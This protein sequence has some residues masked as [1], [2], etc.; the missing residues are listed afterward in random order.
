MTKSAAAPAAGLT[1]E[2]HSW[3]WELLL[4]LLGAALQ[5]VATWALVRALTPDDAGIYF[6]GFVIAL[7]LSTL[8]CG[9]STDLPWRS[10]SSAAA[11]GPPAFQRECC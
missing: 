6:R 9:A 7:G 2:A 1:T 3:V 8:R 10:T 4:L 11:P 5:I